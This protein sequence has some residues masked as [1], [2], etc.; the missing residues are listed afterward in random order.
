MVCWAISE[1]SFSFCDLF[2][3]SVI[4]RGPPMRG[5]GMPMRGGRG[6]PQGAR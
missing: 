1:F 2:L 5:R 4:F 3:E 6:G